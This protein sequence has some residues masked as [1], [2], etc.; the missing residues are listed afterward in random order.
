MRI[1]ILSTISQYEWAGTEEVWAQFAKSALSQGHQVHVSLH[2]RVAQSPQVEGLSKL[3]LKI[4]IRRP[5]RPTRLYLLKERLYGDLRSLEAFRPDLLIINA[6]SLFDVLNVPALRQFCEATALPKIFFCHFVAEGF[7]PHSRESVRAMAETMQGWVFVSEHN[8]HLA[9][10]Q[11]AYRFKNAK[12]IVNAA[13]LSLDAPLPWPQQTDEVQFAC[14]AR[15]ETH[16][17]GHDVLLAVL[18]QPHWHD[19]CWHLNLYGTGPDL[20]YIQQLISYYDLG[21]RVTLRGYASD[22]LSV[23]QQNHLMV[24]PSRGEGTPLAVLEAMMCARPTVTTDVGGNREILEHGRTGWIADV[25]TVHSFDAVLDDAWKQ[26]S[27][28]QQIGKAA[29][30]AALLRSQE[31]PDQQLLAYCHDPQQIQGLGL[32]LTS[33]YQSACRGNPGLVVSRKC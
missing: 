33:A 20:D 28:W 19:R 16:W 5:F 29:H 21:D 13:R 25:A 10:R 23:W 9:E 7:M 30:Q 32:S 11:L 2:W 14:V 31:A 3:G 8:R 24:L 22:I 6:G 17:K 27:N 12:V 4:S 18:A 26:R 15:L 1:G